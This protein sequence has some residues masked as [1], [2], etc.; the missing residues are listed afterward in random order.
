MK[1]MIFQKT[2]ARKLSTIFLL[3]CMA[4]S[5]VGCK[6]VPEG[7]GDAPAS[8]TAAPTK[9]DVPLV[10]GPA[11]AKAYA[12]DLVY[13]VPYV[14]EHRVEMQI[15]EA[16]PRDCAW[17]QTNVHRALPIAL[18]VP[19][20]AYPGAEIT[21]EVILSDG[22]FARTLKGE[23]GGQPYGPAYLGDHFVLENDQGIFWYP[24][25]Y[26]MENWD[27]ETSERPNSI[28]FEGDKAYVDVIVRADA[29]IVGCMAILIY[30]EVLPTVSGY[31]GTYYFPMLL[32]AASC[33]L[34]NGEYQ[35]VD[36]EEMQALI[37]EWKQASPK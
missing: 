11:V 33:P 32:G 6:A 25:W 19:E 22:I 3:L 5:F 14:L 16:V 15:C 34:Q 36:V 12:H 24:I 30:T 35:D 18:S 2:A 31:T 37:E 1:H 9:P 4:L 27:K 23:Y 17:M 7:P 20:E 13:T 10:I 8:T 21:F 28:R 29:H 26:D